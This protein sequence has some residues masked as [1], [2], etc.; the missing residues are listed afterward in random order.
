MG[1]IQWCNRDKDGQEKSHIIG[2]VDLRR[3][4]CMAPILLIE[5]VT[6]YKICTS[7]SNLQFS[8][9]QGASMEVCYNLVKFVNCLY[10]ISNIGAM[11]LD[12]QR[13][14]KAIA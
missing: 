8:L 6:V 1:F 2:F 3:S 4:R 11:H 5:G 14:N 13:S 12:L 10:S 7:L 9:T